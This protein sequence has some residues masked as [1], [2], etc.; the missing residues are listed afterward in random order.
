MDV[1]VLGNFVL[2]RK[3]ENH[4]AEETEAGIATGAN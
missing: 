2:E 1:L 4:R 3:S